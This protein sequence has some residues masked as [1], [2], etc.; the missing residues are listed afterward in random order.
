MGQFGSEFPGGVLSAPFDLPS[1]EP[2]PL[3]VSSLLAQEVHL[4]FSQLARRHPSPATGEFTMTD[5]ASSSYVFLNAQ[6]SFPDALDRRSNPEIVRRR[7]RI[8]SECL[9]QVHDADYRCSTRARHQFSAQVDYQS[10]TCSGSRT[11]SWLCLWMEWKSL[12]LVRSKGL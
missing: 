9:L 4:S 3:S 1:P 11:R 6:S 10:E 7:V 12:R 5:T 2:L 8:T